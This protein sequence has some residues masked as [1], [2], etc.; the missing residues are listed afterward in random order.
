MRRLLT[1]LPLLGL[2]ALPA[3]SAPVRFVACVG[4]SITEG[5]PSPNTPWCQLLGQRRQGQ[6]FA[7]INLGAGGLRCDEVESGAVPLCPSCPSFASFIANRSYT[8]V[9]LMC[10]A[11]DL[12]QGRTADQ[13]IGTTGTPGPLRRMVT[14]ARAAGIPVTVMT[15]TPLGG[16]AWYTP[17]VEGRH[18]DVN[19]RIRALATTTAPS[20]T[21]V[22]AYNVLATPGTTPVATAISTYPGDGLTM[23]AAWQTTPADNLHLGAAGNVRLADGIDA[24]TGAVP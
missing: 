22:E 3:D 16:N 6:N 17:T 1:A 20:V 19:T 4:D 12:N 8:H 11:N 15:V 21:V 10:G 5:V 9:I 18:M 24:T 23:S 13:I 14:A 7:V 2:L